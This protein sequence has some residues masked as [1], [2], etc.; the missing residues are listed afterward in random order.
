ME[1]IQAIATSRLRAS[2]AHAT[3][4]AAFAIVCTA[5]SAA[6]PES[7]ADAGSGGTQSHR[8]N[9]I[10]RYM[11]YELSLDVD[12]KG[13]VAGF[14]EQNLAASK[15]RATFVGRV[16]NRIMRITL[17]GPGSARRLELTFD[18]ASDEATG[19]IGVATWCKTSAG[20]RGA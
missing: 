1:R 5:A 16:R 13:L 9:T 17:S 20:A 3:L 11:E 15:P 7:L 8:V 2:S 10:N 14:I 4:V 18:P 12:E 6:N 19:R